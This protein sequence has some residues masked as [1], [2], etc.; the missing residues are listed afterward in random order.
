MIKNSINA[1]CIAISILGFSSVA[2]GQEVEIYIPGASNET[3]EA[4]ETD[5]LLARCLAT[6]M[7]AYCSGVSLSKNGV[8]LESNGSSDIVLETFIIDLS[9]NQSTPKPKVSV[10]TDS[11]PQDIKDKTT[12]S[13]SVTSIGIEIQFDFNSN[14][15]R[16]DQVEKMSMLAVALADEINAGARFAVIGH[17]DGKGSDAYNCGLSGTRATAVTTT[18]LLNG[19][20]NYLLSV[21]AGEALLKNKAK[22]DSAKNRRVSF[23]KLGENEAATLNAFQSLCN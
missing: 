23:L 2:L 18:L 9:D 5:N 16:A 10:K 22:P 11:G 14:K 21:G 4:V 8:A 3:P 1:V 7:E 19:A 17:T 13:Q 20:Q 15:I 12:S 6:G